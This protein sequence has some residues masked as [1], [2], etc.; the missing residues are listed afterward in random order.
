MA[1]KKLVW[2]AAGILAAAVAVVLF[3]GL[4]PGSENSGGP[5]IEGQ[6]QNFSVANRPTE[7]TAWR[8]GQG[9]KVSLADFS[10]KVVMVNFWATWCAPCVRELPSINRLQA[11]LAG[12]DFTV[13]AINIDTG[14]EAVAAPFAKRLEIAN[15]ALYLDPRGTTSRSMGVNVM[16][17]T[18]VFDRAG[19]EV[20]RL[21][22]GAEWDSPEAVALL[23]WFIDNKS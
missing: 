7:A 10:G 22:G 4:K 11:E 1:I 9:G 20:G 17:T 18:V 14:G 19:N 3:V 13:V 16:P 23:R 15:L 2:P 5:R 12:D 21:E 6:V 8:D